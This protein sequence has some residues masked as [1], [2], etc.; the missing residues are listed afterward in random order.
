MAVLKSRRSC[1]EKCPETKINVATLVWLI[2]IGNIIIGHPSLSQSRLIRVPVGLAIYRT[3][4]SAVY[5]YR[6]IA[7]VVDRSVFDIVGNGG[8]VFGRN[9]SEAALPSPPS[10]RRPSVVVCPGVGQS[11][12]PRLDERSVGFSV[13]EAAF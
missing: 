8:S 3:N 13:I 12:G 9:S 2:E 4:S 11:P 6:C 5:K 7:A 10:D 1:E